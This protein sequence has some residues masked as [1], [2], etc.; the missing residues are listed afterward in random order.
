MVNEVSKIISLSAFFI[1]PD[2][3]ISATLKKSI[4]SPVWLN[5]KIKLAWLGRDIGSMQHHR[6][7]WRFIL[8][9]SV[10]WQTGNT[11]A[12][13]DCEVCFTLEPFVW[14]QCLIFLSLS[15]GSVMAL[16][17]SSVWSWDWFL[18]SATSPT[19]K[20]ESKQLMYYESLCL[21]TYIFDWKS[22]HSEK[23]IKWQWA[24][25]V[26]LFQSCTSSYS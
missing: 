21:R 23:E 14:V 22:R 7:C 10:L 25:W 11:L 9:S 4:A 20:Q 3:G 17:H 13:L 12:F 18:H 5:Y 1:Y 6:D 8:D 2:A 26:W 24:Q 19:Q 15:Y 16:H